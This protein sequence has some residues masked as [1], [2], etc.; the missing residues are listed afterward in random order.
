[1]TNLGEN[2]KRKKLIKY[3]LKILSYLWLASLMVGLI[4]FLHQFFY[5]ELDDDNGAEMIL[6]KI[7]A[8]R[9]GVLRRD[10]YYSSELRVINTQLIYS[11]LFRF[12]SDWHVVRLVGNAVMY[13]LLLAAVWY[14]CRELHILKYY[15]V[16]A[17]MFMI[18]LSRDY[19]LFALHSAY[20]LPHLTLSI[21]LLAMYLHY[22]QAEKK[23]CRTCLAVLMGILSFFIGLGGI[24]H[25]I[26]FYLPLV[27]SGFFM[28][29]QQRKEIFA[30]RLLDHRCIQSCLLAV[31]I[32]IVAIF[33]FF[34]NHLILKKIYYFSN[35]LSHDSFFCTIHAENVERTINGWLNVYGYQEG[36]SIFSLYLICNMLPAIILL[37]LF[38]ACKKAL[39]KNYY[40]VQESVLITFWG[41]GVFFLS[42]LFVF[43]TMWY[44]ERYIMPISVFA[45]PLMFVVFDKLKIV[46]R[47]KNILVLCFA[48]LLTLCAGINYTSYAEMDTSQETRIVSDILL[49]NGYYNGYS[50]MFWKFGDCI[51]EYSNG[52]IEVWKKIYDTGTAFNE[53]TLHRNKRWLEDMTHDT[54]IPTG[55]VFVIIEEPIDVLDEGEILYHSDSVIVYGYNSYDELCRDIDG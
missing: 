24:R 16:I 18:P 37:L 31:S 44:E 5:L 54:Q 13:L 52:Q 10:W 40:N 17:A 11:V 30:K 46:E 50:F 51:T 14:L 45:F 48:F 23:S 12:C 26:V 32:S 6:S 42:I 33:G 22:V 34:I 19:Y 43:S 21:S 35:Y 49:E 15:C 27:C 55:K 25:I 47:L 1:M 8:Q 28:V 7:L 29:Y 38:L 41:S 9:G 39:E 36:N 2:M 4:I 20:L 53:E 3:I